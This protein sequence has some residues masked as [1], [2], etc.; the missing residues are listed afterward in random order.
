MWCKHMGMRGCKHRGAPSMQLIAA[1]A[2]AAPGLFSSR[3]G[4]VRGVGSGA[5]M[6]GW[7]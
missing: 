3:L 6:D 4:G 5:E 1:G 7:L 2:L